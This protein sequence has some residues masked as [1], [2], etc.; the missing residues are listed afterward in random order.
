MQTPLQIRERLEQIR[1]LRATPSQLRTNDILWVCDVVERL[2]PKAHPKG[3]ACTNCGF[4]MHNR[5]IHCPNCHRQT[6]IQHPYARRTVQ[7]PAAPPLQ[8]NDCIT[9]G[10][11]IRA[12]EG[13]TIGECGC[14]YHISCLADWAKQSTRCCVHAGKHIPQ[15]FITKYVNY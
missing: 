2:L 9:C 8:A 13:Y 15:D 10:N 12:N 3:K 14:R 6:Y 11:A 7:P 1:A 5:K 4:K